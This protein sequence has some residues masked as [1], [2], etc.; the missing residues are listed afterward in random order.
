MKSLTRLEITAAIASFALIFVSGLAR[1]V[2]LRAGFEQKTADLATQC[3]VIA[4]F[5][6]FALA[7]IG[8]ALHVFVLLQLRAGN[9]AAPI[10]RLLSDHETGLTFAL[11][12]L[13]GSGMLVALPFILHDMVGLQP[14]IGRSRGVLVAD[15][16][17][18]F[19][20]VK[21][22]STLK[23]KEP[24][25]MAD[26]TYLDVQTVVFDYRI[27]DSGMHFPQSRYYW[28]ATRKTDPQHIA[29]INIGI[30]PRK[31]PK[32][33]LEAF[34]HGLQAQL[35]ADGWMPG[36]RIADSEET[37]RLWAGS[38]TSGDGRY[39]LRGNTLLIFETNRMD[40]EKRDEPPGSGGYILY[41]DLRPKSDYPD[42]VYEPS[43][44][45]H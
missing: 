22:R 8:L 26:G 17:M 27:G 14:P 38:R 39:W 31:L 16:G 19:E 3:A 28:L 11:W 30:T 43:A 36:H 4:L 41:V 35:L 40:E 9:G 37:I 21:Q 33:Y 1:Q 32:P 20:E 42:L 18:I 23:L 7:C 25:A 34:Q 15:I 6:V 5:F 10:I 45:P 24:R 13:L 2:A 44:W 29:E 12:G